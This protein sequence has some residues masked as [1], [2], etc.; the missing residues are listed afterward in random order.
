MKCPRCK[1]NL[2][3]EIIIDINTSLHVDSCNNCG[4]KWFDAKELEQIDQLIEPTLFEIRNIPN[5]RE[6]I[7]PMICPSC[8]GITVMRKAEHDRDKRVIID[9]CSKCNGIWLD[10]GELQAIR[11]ENWLITLKKLFKWLVIGE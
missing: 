4:G 2:S 1:Q 11:K 8:N 10:K 5:K 7:K 6:Q 3:K 9:Y